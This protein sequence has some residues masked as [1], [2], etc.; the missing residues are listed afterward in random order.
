V[1][2]KATVSD[3]VAAAA[4]I[5]AVQ[6]GRTVFIGVD[7]CGG[8]GKTTIAARLAEAL[9]HAVVVH[10]DDFAAPTVPEWDWDRMEAQL[11]APLRAGRNARYQRWDW[12]SDAGAEW[13]DVPA[14]VP[15]VIEG[16][17]STRREVHAP[18]ALQIWVD[19]PREA[20][21]DRALDR[22]GPA[23]MH[24]WVDEWMP[25]EDEYVARE[26][27]ERRVDLVVSGIRDAITV[28]PCREVDLERLDREV[29]SQAVGIWQAHF[30]RQTD[31]SV[32][33]LIA[34]LADRPIGTGLLDWRG[35]RETHASGAYPTVPTITNLHVHPP[36]QGHGAGTAIIAAAERTAA[37]RG[38]T[39]VTIGVAADNPRAARLYGRLGYARTGVED[40]SRYCW[41]DDDGAVHAEVEHVELLV[42]NL[43]VPA[44][45]GG[46]G[47]SGAS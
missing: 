9:P 11:L 41:T 27:P 22:D 15:V 28:R 21:L 20:R 14:G 36:F 40:E 10:V 2:S 18:W 17:S 45:S 30:S 8:A 12:D 34:W 6:G 13:H 38:H 3:A 24:R 1:T 42:K 44:E 33:F 23:L 39:H 46:L 5:A 26:H 31:G 29:P 35:S 43:A 25:S 16:V 32:V 47:E 37:E 7:G 4:R 19:A